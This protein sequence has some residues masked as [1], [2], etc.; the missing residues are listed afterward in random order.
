MARAPKSDPP[1]I[2]VCGEDD[3]GV[4][5]RA[6]DIFSKWT[7]EGGGM[8]Q[9]IINATASN[10]G[11]ATK[12]LAKL[13]EGM[14][15]LPFFGGTK[16]IWFQD[17]NFLADDRTSASSQVTAVL[18]DLAQELKKFDWN[19]VRLLITAG[20]VDKRKVFFKACEAVGSIEICA[21]WPQDE[22]VWVAMAEDAAFAQF[23]E[24]GKDI[25]DAAVRHLATLVGPNQRL[26]NSEVEKLI[27]YVGDRQEVTRKDVD[28]IVTRSKQAK[29]FA[30]GDALGKRDLPETLRVL[31]SEMWDIRNRIT[32]EKS[33]IG[34]LYGLIGKVRTML[35]LKEMIAARWVKDEFSDGDRGAYS[36]FKAQ[37]DKAPAEDLPADKRLNPLAMNPW[38]LYVALP[39]A[40]NY[41]R[42]ELVR[43]MDLLLKSNL[44]LV[45]SGT[46]EA[47]VLQ[48]ALVE[49]VGKN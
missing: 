48:Q 39:H 19:G 44:R 32:K 47:V 12:A 7:G 15:T 2:L 23:R 37:L 31:D 21:G 22:K 28:V 3:F 36:R 1:L 25:S 35:F 42:D 20:K 11:E 49:I 13:R 45:T 43:A 10:S 41:S 33:S 9:E 8:D 30:L 6:R 17:C 16:V 26:L 29:A 24:A 34:L 18:A 40:R 46:D 5:Q 38:M 4:K 27:L 14:Q